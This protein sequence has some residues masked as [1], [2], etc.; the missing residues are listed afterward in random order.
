LPIHRP[1][2]RTLITTT[3]H[4]E[5]YDGNGYP[6]RLAG[7]QIALEAQII[8]VADAIEAMM[9]DRPYR[10]A[11]ET[12]D[13]IEELNRYSGSQFDPLVTKEAIHV[14]M[15]TDGTAMNPSDNVRI[16]HQL[17]INAQAS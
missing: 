15:A 17:K 1:S 7:N 16:S 6:D 5:F 10:K 14:L 3:R 8:A 13:V 11:F 12:A 4:Y 9:S 2:L